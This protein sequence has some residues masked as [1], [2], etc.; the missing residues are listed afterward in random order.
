MRAASHSDRVIAYS[1]SPCSSPGMRT[2][3]SVAKLR[4]WRMPAFSITRR[5][6]VCTAIVSATMRS[7]GAVAKPWSMSAARALAAVSLAPTFGDQSVAELGVGR[8]GVGSWAE[9]EPAEKC[10]GGLL[11]RDPEPEVRPAFVVAEEV[12]DA[13]D[14]LGSVHRLAVL[15]EAAHARVAVEGEQVV[16][17]VDREPAQHQP[18]GLEEHALDRWPSRQAR[19]R[20][21]PPQ[22]VMRGEAG[23]HDE[24]RALGHLLART[25][26]VAADATDLVRRQRT[27]RDSSQCRG[28]Q[29]R[30]GPPSDGNRREAGPHQQCDRRAGGVVE[31]P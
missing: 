22:R 21:A 11:D 26:H 10:A 24:A 13:L 17:V 5:D 2:G 15:D 19:T 20:S 1:T 8:V 3:H 23:H 14:R 27:D 16:D 6:A 25:Q 7:I 18:V 31:R 4:T 28:E 9:V 12:L 30:P 29:H